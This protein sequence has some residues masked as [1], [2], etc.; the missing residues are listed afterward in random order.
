MANL[1]TQ[2]TAPAEDYIND[3]AIEYAWA[4]KASE[5]ASIHQNLLINCD[6]KTLKL[7]K[8]QD[9]IYEKF[10][11]VFPNLDIEVVTEEQLK[12]DNKKIW[13]DFC[14]SFSEVDDYNMGSLMRID[15]KTI[16]SA[17]NTLIVPRIQFLAI[18]GARNVE[19][20]NAKYKDIVV[21]D[22]KKALDS[23]TLDI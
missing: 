22:Y 19:G 9:I 15:A 17:Q 23:G 8:Y 12:G 4:M 2:L 11:E 13:H 20:V 5:R 16:Y 6:T 7:N 14:E 1:E 3:P 21:A 18:E 10:R